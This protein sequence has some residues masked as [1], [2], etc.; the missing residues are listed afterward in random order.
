[1]L[2]CRVFRCRVF[3]CRIFICRVFRVF[4]CRVI[5]CRVFRFYMCFFQKWSCFES[6]TISS[7]LDQM[8]WTSLFS[9]YSFPQIHF[10]LKTCTLRE[11]VLHVFFASDPFFSFP[12]QVRWA[13]MYPGSNFCFLHPK[14]INASLSSLFSYNFH[15]F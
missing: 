15:F 3:R 8:F 13:C 7:L 10:S 14:Y 1:M 9:R 4:K 6:D 5:K 2:S 11:N 12:C